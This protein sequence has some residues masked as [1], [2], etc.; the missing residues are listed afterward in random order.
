MMLQVGKRQHYSLGMFTR[1]RYSELLTTQYDST[2]FYACTTDVD[3][4][5]MSA[6]ANLAALWEPSGTQI[7]NENL[8]WQ[9]IPIHPLDPRVFSTACETFTKLVADVISGAELFAEINEEYLETYQILTDNSGYVVSSVAGA[10]S[11]WDTLWIEDLNG[12][13]LPSWTSS[14]LPRTA[15]DVSCL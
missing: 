13:S 3:R 14:V 8:S 2:K 12:F 10:A 6:Q 4:T 7:W 15:E 9:P 11:V 5:H 1:N